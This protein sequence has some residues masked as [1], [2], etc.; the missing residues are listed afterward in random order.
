[1]KRAGLAD[2]MKRLGEA[3]SSKDY[4]AAADAFMDADSI[5]D[6]ETGEGDEE[7]PEKGKG[8][9]GLLLMAEPKKK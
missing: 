7:E 1:M 3:L 5:T 8:G 4:D 2:A 6:M 9:L